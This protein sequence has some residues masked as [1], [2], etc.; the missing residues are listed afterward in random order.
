MTAQTKAKSF[1]NS[2]FS[3]QLWSLEKK[4]SGS[5]TFSATW[6]FLIFIRMLFYRPYGSYAERKR[7]YSCV[8]SPLAKPTTSPTAQCRSINCWS[9]PC[10]QN[11]SSSVQTTGKASIFECIP[12]C[13]SVASS[14]EFRHTIPNFLMPIDLFIFYFFDQCIILSLPRLLSE[15]DF[16]D[17]TSRGQYFF[18]MLRLET[19]PY[20]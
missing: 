17:M 8:L 16:P 2:I 1:L 20:V 19:V 10:W 15:K 13:L 14:R 18:L 3:K 9:I 12:H 7:Y 5:Q 4:K 6:H 11:L